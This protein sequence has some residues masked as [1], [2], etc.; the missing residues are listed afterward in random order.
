M[1]K[2]RLFALILLTV[3]VSGCAAGRAFRRGEEAARNGDWDTAVQH[4][5]TALQ[6]KPE[7]AEYKIALE[8]AM[9]NAS[10][11]HLT[12]ARELEEKDQLDAAL[13]EYR[14][15]L[16]L[17]GSNRLAAARVSE[18]ERTIRERIEKSRP[19]P[20]IEQL[21]QQARAQATPL[22]NPANRDPLKVQFNNA[23]LRDV[24]N[25]IGQQTGINIQIDPQLFQDRAVTVSLEGVTVEEA[26]QTILSTNGHFYKVLN[27]TTI[28]VAL[29]NAQGHQKYDDLVVRVFYL[30]HA[31]AQE[32]SQIINTIMRIPQMTVQP[33]LFPN[34]TANT[35]TVR[36]T[37][38]VVDIIERLIRANDRPRAEVV[39]DV[40]ILEV[41]RTRLKQYGIDLNAYAVNLIFSP[42]VAPPNTSATPGTPSP[43]PPPFNLNT[44]SQGV[45]TADFYM[46]VPTAVIRFLE[47]D[48]RSRLLAKPQLRGQEGQ[49][50]TLNLGEEIPVVSTVFGAAV[51]GGF[52][53]I[54]QSSFNYRPVGINMEMT[55]RVTYDGEV[56]LELIIEN[57]AL[58]PSIDVAGQSVP[59]FASRKVGTKLRLR[60][61]ESNLLAGLIREEERR[62]ISG[63]P[64]LINVPVLNQIFAN[65]NR[66][67]EQR[68]IVMLLT[69]HI[70][71]TH[72]LTVDDLAPI[73][74]GTQQ[75]IGLSGPPQLIAPPP[76]PEE[77]PAGGQVFS[78]ASVP[79]APAGGVPGPPAA[80]TPGAPLGPSPP[81]PGTTSIPTPVGPL[82]ERPA[83]PPPPA[84][85]P[86]PA[87]EPG[88]AP[89][90]APP[91]PTGAAPTPDTTPRDQVPVPP[92]GAPAAP[93]GGAAQILVTASPEMRVAG[94]PYTTPLSV[95]NASRLSTLTV[96]VTFNP[97]VLRVR[98]VQEGTFMRQG[99]VT[100][101][102]TPRIDN[103]AGR[104]DIAI[105][106]TGDQAGASGTGLLAA[107][108][109]DAIG[110]GNSLIQVSGVGSNPEGGSV[111]LQFAPV[112]VTVR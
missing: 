90:G 38:P 79:G 29:D 64:G 61:G 34:K 69:P 33:A 30:S 5:Q 10:R 37:A 109:F 40:Q 63:I 49:K 47:Q 44:I 93:A 97:S 76:A 59:S 15:A 26:L 22:L 42:E 72:E 73:Y 107:L 85:P 3:L 39:V 56:I 82:P 71:R 94:G 45:S 2:H 1:S 87:T 58:G 89:P 96:T 77:A 108:L 104:V 13:L 11:D 110:Q 24:L 14:R 88:A 92:G 35:I 105:T 112:T 86:A 7:Q 12:R 41:S 8:R 17:D 4:Y 83:F 16:E 57:S 100:A 31:D 55:P 48:S 19:R 67:G 68:D 95:N 84:V 62:A 20:A 46:A 53:S 111:A 81:P 21:R 43:S 36:A 80:A 27:P 103:V 78:P 91:A 32:V 66:S 102:F 98:N 54:P 52:A 50:L 65:N 75:N 25:F 6:E 74:I 60:E 51:S 101:A 28:V 18:L 106:R 23:S 9:Q 99:G 70:V